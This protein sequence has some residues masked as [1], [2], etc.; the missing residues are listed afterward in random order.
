MN[1]KKDILEIEIELR[2]KMKDAGM[3]TQSDAEKRD[4]ELDL[5]LLSHVQS[6]YKAAQ[7]NLEKMKGP[8]KPS[9]DEDCEYSSGLSSDGDLDMMNEM[10]VLRQ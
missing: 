5:K 9:A 7:K 10:D 2:Q 6:S 3:D 1:L 8:V 4:Q